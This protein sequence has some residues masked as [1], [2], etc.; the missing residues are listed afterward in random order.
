MQKALAA[1]S[2]D[3]PQDDELEEVKQAL[4]N[5]LTDLYS[6]DFTR[7]CNRF[8]NELK[9]FQDVR[10]NAMKNAMQNVRAQ[11][12]SGT[13][14]V[15]DTDDDRQRKADYRIK[16]LRETLL[17]CKSAL[18]SKKG[19]K[20]QMVFDMLTDETSVFAKS[21]MPYTISTPM[22][23]NVL[24]ADDLGVTNL[25]VSGVRNVLKQG[26]DALQL[27]LATRSSSNAHH[28]NVSVEGFGWIKQMHMDISKM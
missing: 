26:L 27:L 1:S 17:K 21:L 12:L 2:V 16:E 6:L 25:N 11:A 4:Q 7:Y 10:A 9:P 24:E 15:V 14:A 5:R 13:P 8:V 28:K 18:G 3:L 19:D 23:Q 22:L 20:Q